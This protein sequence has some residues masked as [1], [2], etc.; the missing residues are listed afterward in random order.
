MPENKTLNVDELKDKLKKNI[1]KNEDEYAGKEI[2]E[3][4]SSLMNEFKLGS[5][6]LVLE[7]LKSVDLQLKE[8][9]YSESNGSEQKTDLLIS[10]IEKIGEELSKINTNL[11]SLYELLVTKNKTENKTENVKDK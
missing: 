1:K 10:S 3:V 7:A 11:C 6:S 9:A 4:I 8:N 2:K 5:P